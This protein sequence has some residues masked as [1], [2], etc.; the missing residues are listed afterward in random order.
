MLAAKRCTLGITLEIWGEK[1]KTAELWE[2]THIRRFGTSDY[3]RSVSVF[4]SISLLTWIS[5]RIKQNR[6]GTICLINNIRSKPAS[7]W[8]RNRCPRRR[9]PSGNDR[10]KAK[11]TWFCLSRKLNARQ[12]WMGCRIVSNYFS[13]K[14]S[15]NT[16]VRRSTGFKNAE[17]KNSNTFFPEI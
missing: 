16:F 8:M 10:S 3:L 14:H 2:A 6:A 13:V 7:S 4:I 5:W 1:K 17:E 9:P 12:L 11:K 15:L